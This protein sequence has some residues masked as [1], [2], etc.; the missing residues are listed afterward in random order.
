[1]CSGDGECIEQIDINEYNLNTNCPFRCIPIKC[2]NFHVCE[3]IL[4]ECYLKK[5]GICINCDIAF[6]LWKSGKVVLKI[7][8]IDECCVCLEVKPLV[9]LPKC[10]HTLCFSCFREVY[11]PRNVCH[12]DCEC[13]N[14]CDCE[15]V[16]GSDCD[17]DE[18]DRYLENSGKC[19]M[20]RIE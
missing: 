10:A 4:P 11:L 20:C 9:E 8:P 12:C 15:I 3:E 6:G 5:G 1:M 13:E 19:P 16:C 17:Q 2:K 7:Q 14:D 18:I